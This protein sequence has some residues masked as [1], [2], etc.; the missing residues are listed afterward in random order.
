VRSCLYEGSVRH[1]RRGEVSHEF[2]YPLFMAYLDLDELPGVF[3]GRWLWSARG[4]APAWFRRADYLG[5]PTEALAESV[6]RLV[7]ER[8]GERPDGPIGLL[9]NLRYLG[10]GFNPVSFYYCYDR[11]GEALR[12]T[13]ADVTNTPWG[14][15]HAYVLPAEGTS[16]HGTAAVLEGSFPKQL[17]VSPLM[18][19]D[20]RYAWRMTVPGERLAVHIESHN[21]AGESVF[22]ATLAM[23]R[24]ELS[25]A[26]MR[27]ALL[28]YPLLTMRIIARIYGQSL[29][30]KLKGASYFPNPGQEPGPGRPA[31]HP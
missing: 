4:P 23:E 30:L 22:D 6:R 26:A 7:A 16:D 14:E 12:A 28:R 19:M 17:H 9:T 27:H 10:Y 5:E 13:I 8:T 2:R 24:R 25:P 11:G 31:V 18:G 21:Q 3:D 20:H 29:A 1:R 15:R